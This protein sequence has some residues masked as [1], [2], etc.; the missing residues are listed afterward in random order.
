MTLT[1][2][3]DALDKWTEENAV[4]MRYIQL[5]DLAEGAGLLDEFLSIPEHFVKTQDHNH[6]WMNCQSLA[7]I[8]ALKRIAGI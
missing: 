2:T 3:Q 4:S 7:K 1:K 5:Q 6:F 8:R